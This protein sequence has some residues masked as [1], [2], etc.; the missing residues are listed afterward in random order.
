MTILKHLLSI[1][2]ITAIFLPARAQTESTQQ[3]DLVERLNKRVNNSPSEL[4]YIQTNKDIYETGEDLWF[5]VYLLNAQYLIPSV[6]SKTLYLQL[7]KEDTKK[8]I[9]QEKYEIL[10][11]IADGQV[12]L[13]SKL[14]EGDYL[15]AAFTSNSFFDDTSEFKAIRRIKI[16]QDV[17][18]SPLL[19][20]KSTAPVSFSR[21]Q[22]TALPE[23]G[24]LVSGIPGKVAFKAVNIKGEPEEVQ[25]TLFEDS[26]SILEFKSM[27]AGMG[28]FN[29]IPNAGKKYVIKLKEPAVDTLYFLP[30]ILLSGITIIL[31]GRDKEALTLRVSQSQDLPAQDLYL[32]VQCRGEVYGITSCRLGN[33]LRIKIPLSGLPQGPAEITLFNSSLV[34]V[35]ERLIYINL[36]KKLNITTELSKEIYPTRGKATLKIS[37]K[38]ENG[39]PV[40]ANL[41]VT[42]F[43]KLYQNPRDSNNILTYYYLSTQL[44]GRIFN[45]SFYFNKGKHQEEALDLLMLT[46]GWRKYVWNDL[47]P[48]KIQETNQQI[49]FDGIKG[50]LYYQ[51]QRNK[52][53]KEQTFVMAFSP[54]KDSSKVLI[55]AD[56]TGAFFVSEGR[57][58][59]VGK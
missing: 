35:A 48:E 3:T 44:K 15:I 47:N 52:I 32:R 11:G 26:S 51:N 17:N 10:D 2:L 43:D 59:N 20:S 53:P 40:V 8:V 39:R 27:H 45:P 46:Q 22:F 55:P 58:K 12:Y 42:V 29:F 21:I 57:L 41:G 34:P 24:N 6:L 31:A 33:E 14:S 23:G 54:N 13:D 16:I 36:D 4:A 28:S 18:S 56:S 1:I 5:K 49:I 30:E 19:V 7:F 25:G 38:D 37:V 50:E 9:W